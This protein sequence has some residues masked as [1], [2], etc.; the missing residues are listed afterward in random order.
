MITPV[1]PVDL[2]SGREPWWLAL[3]VAAA[4]LVAGSWAY[5]NNDLASPHFDD[6]HAILEN[7]PIRVFHQ[8]VSALTKPGD[9]LGRKLKAYSRALGPAA[10]AIYA[11][12]PLRMV[13][14]WSFALTFHDHPF[15]EGDILETVRGWHAANDR[16]HLLNGL[17]VFCL[18]WLT[19]TSPVLR[20]G[21]ARVAW[22]ILLS[23][24]AALVFVTHPLQVQAVTY[25]VQRTESLCAT[26]YLLALC[27]H[28]LA[29]RLEHGPRR[30]RAPWKTGLVLGAG[31]VLLT[32]AALVARTDLLQLAGLVRLVGLVALATT[33]ALVVLVRRGDDEPLHV[34]CVLG[35]LVAFGLGSL[36][37]E[38]GATLPAALLAW[39]LLFVP[40]APD[41][42]AAPA[43][44]PRVWLLR[45]AR[46]GLRTRARDLAPWV[47]IIGCVVLLVPVFAG[48]A[49]KGQLLADSVG[50]GGAGV[51]GEKMGAGRYLLT[52]QN[53]LCT[54]GRLFL[55]P[56]GQHLDW[57]YPLA[58]GL[59]SGTTWLALVSGAL[60]VGA[61]G[62]A[63]ARGGRGRVAAFAVVLGLAVLAPTSTIIV[64]PDVIFE[65]RMYLP[66]AGLALLAAVVL[67]RLAGRLLPAAHRPWVL[68][69]AALALTVGLGLLA[70]ARNEVFATEITL[71][72][73]STQR[74]PDKP[75]A[76]TNLGLAMSNTEPALLTYTGGQALGRPVRLPDG[77]YVVHCTTDPTRGVVA[78]VPAGALRSIATT[79]GGPEA[80]IAC[81][82]RALERDPRYAKAL[83]NKA[84]AHIALWRV[85][86]D[87]KKALA[88]LGL[89]A[90]REGQVALVEACEVQ[91]LVHEREARRQAELA[92]QAMS[93]I[94]SPDPEQ[95]NN[96]AANLAMGLGQTE[97]AVNLL[98]IC[99]NMYGA[100]PT[101][102]VTLS[103]LLLYRGFDRYDEAVAKGSADPIAGARE[104]WTEALR[105]L[106]LYLE[107]GHPAFAAPAREIHDELSSYLS[108]TKPVPPK[109]S[110]ER[111]LTATRKPR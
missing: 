82:D 51:L 6:G 17:L 54:Y 100:P 103:H 19:L 39:D 23:G 47:A 73:D 70:R 18:G 61:L 30:R 11:A 65:H 14:N 76:W 64:L 77:S 71:W 8:R 74:A 79:E 89:R 67:D 33:A 42:A 98:K 58:G 29:R 25:L 9:G 68:V 16:I 102:M 90:R 40:P 5:G 52:Q 104:E 72:R 24:L 62:L 44:G 85:S 105:L 94:E 78:V 97:Q 56:Y 31:G 63:L 28:G 83:N 2:A 86:N 91:A 34:L 26:F 96:R 93:R 4:I 12:N 57:Q 32:L 88:E 111:D 69:G 87:Q 106:G 46:S 20:R 101:S 13:T 10:Q 7:Q 21:G 50:E 108:G 107:G 49:L 43:G 1:Q 35:S 37:K 45:A 15:G 99:V 53:V 95:L 48:F 38:I 22:P 3:I 66:L 81:Y 36:T 60:V 75:R 80:A 27:L 55:L 109:G 84:I 41:A 92:E 59:G 110:P